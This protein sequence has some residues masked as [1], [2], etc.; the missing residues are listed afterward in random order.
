MGFFSR[1]NEKLMFRKSIDFTIPPEMWLKQL[2]TGMKETLY[3]NI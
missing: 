3:Y 2:E 1:T